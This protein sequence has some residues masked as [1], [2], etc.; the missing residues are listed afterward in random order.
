MPIENPDGSYTG[1]SF[2]DTIRALQSPVPFVI[3]ERIDTKSYFAKKAGQQ[4]QNGT[5]YFFFLT[6][7]LFE[8]L[9]SS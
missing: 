3:S 5:S 9:T 8:P 4:A 6:P 1:E 7:V 2:M